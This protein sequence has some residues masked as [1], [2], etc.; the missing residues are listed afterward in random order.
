M[1]LILRYLLTF[2]FLLAGCT[3]ITVPPEYHYAEIQT[4][5]F[6]IATWQ[7]INNPT[8]PYKI[9]IEGDGHAFNAHGY[10]SQ[11]PTPKGTLIREIAFGDKNANVIYLSRPCQYIKGPIC[12]QKYWTTARFAPAVIDA[13][14][15]AIKQIAQNKPIVLVGFSGG[16]QVAGLLA[17]T[18]PDLN[19]KKVI[20]IAGNLDHQMWTTYH[21][22]PSLSQSLNL[23]DYKT[24]FLTI[25]QIHYVGS[26]DKVIPPQLTKRFIQDDDL[27]VEVKS[28]D[29][30]SGWNSIFE[31]IWDNK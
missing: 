18:K 1:E 14:Y 2:L 8:A 20:T 25:P 3:S 26:Q 16:A 5:T 17:V 6:I 30:N 31:Q 7:K 9:Y 13:E 21:N 24:Q 27:I 22:L 11:D 28:A 10:P 29:H 15:Q 23:A 4:D 19:V 12:E